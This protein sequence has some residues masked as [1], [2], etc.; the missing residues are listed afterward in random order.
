MESGF[1]VRH[2]ETEANLRGSVNGD[3]A[4]PCPLSPEGEEQARR[5][6]ERLAGVPIDLCVTSEFERT[7]RTAGLALAGRDIPLEVWPELN[8]P[9]FGRYEG[10]LLE[11]YRAWASAHG[12][13]D[14]P[15]GGGE[16]RRAIVARYAAGFRRLLER[17]EE[18]LVA[19][20][21]SLPVAYVLAALRGVDP[22]PR[23]ELVRHAHPYAVSA[24]EL[25]GAVER[26]E[27]WCAAP[28]W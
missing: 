1:L 7:R 25:R 10:G 24:A 28:T 4:S 16:S 13:G 27:A 21:H 8:D 26:L 18:H 5:L 17:P 3:P 6:G 12:S 19:V 15:P 14:A 9:R 20:A 23:A 11:D 2:A 22:A